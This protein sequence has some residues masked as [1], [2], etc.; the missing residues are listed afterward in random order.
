MTEYENI[1]FSKYFNPNNKMLIEQID[2]KKLM[3]ILKTQNDQNVVPRLPP[4]PPL[5]GVHI[6]NMHG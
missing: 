4:P 1:W 3:D 2:F 6:N 5:N